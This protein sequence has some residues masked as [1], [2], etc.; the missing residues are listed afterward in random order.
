MIRQAYSQLRN[1]LPAKVNG[2]LNRGVFAF[3]GKPTVKEDSID[4]ALKFPGRE[5]GGLII[6]ADF[7]MSWAWRY[8]KSGADYLQKGQI[9]RDN[10]PKIINLL[11]EYNVPITF[12]TV[13]HLFLDRCSKGNHDWMQRIPHFDDH[14]KFT[15]GD[16]FEHDPHSDVK[17]AP[18]WYA[19]DLIQLILNSEVSHEIATHTFSHIDCSDKNCPPEVLDDELTACKKEADKLGVNLTSIVFPG[20][21]YGNYEVLKKHGLNIYRKSTNYELSYPYR[22]S[23]DL[24]VTTSSACLEYNLEYRWSP[25]YVYK[26]WKHI[27][28]KAI[29][30]NMIAHFWFH[31]SLEPFILQ[32][33]WPNFLQYVTKKRDIGDLWIGTMKDIA[34]HINNNNII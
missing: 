29:D 33:V 9:E 18:E 30:T 12:A 28:Q 21:T 23:H 22:D 4:P 25:E 7:E 16:W 20:G 2:W 8:T 32:N 17:K 10:F 1:I 15:G 11:E 3:S 19:P 27:I 24:L 34:T 13:G 6:S 26:R 14:W 5:K 31:P